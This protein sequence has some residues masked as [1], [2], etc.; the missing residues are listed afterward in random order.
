MIRTFR[1]DSTAGLPTAVYGLKCVFVFGV[2]V[3]AFT[4]S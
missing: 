1:A 3:E 4:T 2:P